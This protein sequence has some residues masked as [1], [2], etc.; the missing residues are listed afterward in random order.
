MAR[1]SRKVLAQRSG[2]Y[3]LDSSKLRSPN[4]KRSTPLNLCM[5]TR[6]EARLLGLTHFSGIDRKKSPSSPRMLF[7]RFETKYLKRTVRYRPPIEVTQ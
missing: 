6:A 1:P 3:C 7:K 4:S 5:R 2:V